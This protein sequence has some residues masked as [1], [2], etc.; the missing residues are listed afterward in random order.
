[1]IHALKCVLITIHRHNILVAQVCVTSL[2]VLATIIFL[3]SA[4]V[5]SLTRKSVYVTL[6]TTIA[7]HGLSVPMLMAL[8]YKSKRRTDRS[9]PSPA[10][11]EAAVGEDEPFHGRDIPLDEHI[12]QL[13]RQT[14]AHLAAFNADATAT[15]VHPFGPREEAEEDARVSCDL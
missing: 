5:D 10:P 15:R 9:Q 2:L 13:M 7:V 1:M 11:D 6:F 4:L 12:A 3:F 8:S 14:P